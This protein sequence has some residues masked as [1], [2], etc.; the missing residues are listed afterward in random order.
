MNTK[1]EIIN[2]YYEITYKFE[3]AT[4]IISDEFVPKTL[5]GMRKNLQELYEVCNDIAENLKVRGG[6]AS[7]L[8]YTEEEITEMKKSGKYT[9]I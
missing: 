7:N 3:N 5:E 9:F 6:D 2:D 1:N 8:F 4:V